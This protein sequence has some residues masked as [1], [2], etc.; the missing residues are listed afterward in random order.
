LKK[1]ISALNI[2]A[3]NA[4]TGSNRVTILLADRKESLVAEIKDDTEHGVY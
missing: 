4:S 1:G 2:G 3:L